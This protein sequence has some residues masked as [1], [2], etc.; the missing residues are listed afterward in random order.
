MEWPGRLEVFAQRPVIILDGAHN[1]EGVRTL[2]SELPAVVGDQKVRLLFG[3]MND[4]NWRTML[5]LLCKVSSEVVLTQV[6]RPQSA[7]PSALK[8]ALPAQIRTKIVTDPVEALSDMVAEAKKAHV[9]ILVAGSL[10]LIGLVRGH[11]V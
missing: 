11:V 3:S 6:P 1:V 10:Y 8:E 9:P 5:R 4:K 2:V 7:R